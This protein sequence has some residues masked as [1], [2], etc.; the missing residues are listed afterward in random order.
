M[1]PADPSLTDGLAK[2]TAFSN[3]SA[4]TLE[5]L[6]AGT[7]ELNIKR[8]TVVFGRG[9]PP[10]G[11]PVVRSGKLKLSIETPRGDEHVV[12]IMQ[13]GDCFGEAA[14]LSERQHLLTATAVSD[15][16]LLHVGRAT[17]M[18]ELNRDRELSR[19]LIQTLSER[20]YHRTSDLENILFRK[21]VGRVSCFILEQLEGQCAQGN[22]RIR[23]PVRKGLIAS[24][25]NMTQEHFSRTLRELS[26][27]GE[28]AVSG[29]NIDVI[30]EAK[31]RALAY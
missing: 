26:T 21:A 9:T 20:L 5:R 18:A 25:L 19:R 11:V 17:L 28:I 7:T 24:R 16:R 1:R 13:D 15:C 31:L 3:L 10:T 12:E 8:G 23:L 30:D 29:R 22:R 4:E 14:L 2:S 6:A 27:G